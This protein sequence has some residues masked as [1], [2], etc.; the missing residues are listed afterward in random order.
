[1]VQIQVAP[2]IRSTQLLLNIM[3]SLRYETHFF[4]IV[5]IYV[6]MYVSECFMLNSLKVLGELSPSLSMEELK[7]YEL[8][9]DRYEGASR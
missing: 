5:N 2:V 3:I 9:R 8:L 6:C 1:M 4:I 7:K